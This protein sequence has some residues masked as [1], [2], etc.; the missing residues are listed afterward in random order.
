[1]VTVTDSIEIP[2][3]PEQVIGTIADFDTWGDW[4]VIHVGFVG[5]PPE[6]PAPGVS[7]KERVKILGMPGEVEWTVGE[8]ELADPGVI[9]MDGTG[10]MGTKMEVKF[11]VGSEDGGTKVS[12]DASYGGAALTPLLG[13]LEKATKQASAETLEKLRDVV[14]SKAAA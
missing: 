1:V 9:A 14:T 13:Q 5:D 2:A 8:V 10:P 11:S 6:A 4:L 12:Y 3:P 7:F